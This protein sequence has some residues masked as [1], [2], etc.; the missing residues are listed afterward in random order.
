MKIV[1]LLVILCLLAGLIFL[2]ACKTSGEAV[3]PKC[4]A[5]WKCKSANE[6]AYQSANCTWGNVTKC[7]SGCSNG[8]CKMPPPTPTPVNA[9]CTDSDGGLNYYTRGNGTGLYSSS[10]EKGV[11]WGENANKCTARS[12]AKNGY[13][14]HYDCCSDS[15]NSNQI[16]EAY[17]ENGI[18]L[19]HGYQ[20]PNGCLNG[21]CKIPPTPR[22]A[23]VTN[24]TFVVNRS[25]ANV[26]NKT[27]P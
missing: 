11:I 23:N 5:G 14:I 12:D 25:V 26:T 7:Q 19:A 20:C 1:S 2:T 17:C 3:K 4:T 27:R 16:N 8:A 21:A 15:A 9:T 13:S 10:K 24:G 6:R 18:L 22:P